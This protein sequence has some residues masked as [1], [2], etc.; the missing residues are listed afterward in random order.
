MITEIVKGYA[1]LLV[2]I[3]ERVR[4]AQYIAL[5]YLLQTGGAD[6]HLVC[7]EA[8]RDCIPVCKQV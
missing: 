7:R 8:D 1:R 4:A 6:E 3:K 2:E 5:R